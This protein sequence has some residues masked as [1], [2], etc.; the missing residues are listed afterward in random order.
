MED[1]S[2]ANYFSMM[3]DDI[4]FHQSKLIMCLQYKF[5]EGYT[6]YGTPPSAHI[7]SN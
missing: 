3:A 6:Q 2:V 4:H 1:P 5:P 7:C